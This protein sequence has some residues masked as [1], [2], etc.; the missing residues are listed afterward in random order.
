MQQSSAG[1]DTPVST[2]SSSIP[3]AMARGRPGPDYAQDPKARWLALIS[4]CLSLMVTSLTLSA[5]SIAIPAIADQLQASAVMVSWI[6]TALLWGSIVLMLPA[7]RVADIVGR[8]RVYLVGVTLFSI[9]SLLI[10][11]VG[12]IE[13]LLGLRVMQ[14]LSSSMVFGS[15]L[16]VVGSVFPPKARGQALGFAASSVYLGLTAGPLIGGWL[17]E[18]YGWRSVFWM[19]IPLTVLALL[20]VALFL[21]GEWKSET[22]ER[23]DWVGSLLFAA[24][25]SAAFLGISGLP[26]PESIALVGL[27]GALLWWF[28]RHQNRVEYPLI[29]LQVLRQN[30]LLRRSIKASLFMYG[31]NFP[32]VFLLS[33][34][35]QYIQSMSPSEAGQLIL[36]ETLVMMVLAPLA[37]RLSDRFEARIISTLGCLCFA[38]G[39][40]LLIWLQMDTSKLFIVIALAIL[41]LGFGLFSTPNNSAVMGA[42]PRSRMGIASA[43]LSLSRTLGNLVGTALVM[44]LISWSIGEVAIEPEQYPQL[45]WVVKTSLALSGLAALAA[46]Y[47]SFTRGSVHQPATPPQTSAPA[48]DTKGHSGGNS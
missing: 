35:L 48:A 42:V 10:F 12:S 46:C 41:G 27:G 38:F 26:E 33:L 5:A 24:W 4:V 39:F 44:M 23:L 3:P 28:I 21:K 11:T 32:I 17:T 31:A 40:G 6:P 7:G 36:I 15:G 16:A 9:S 8:K 25:V 47:Y 34:Y 30:R 2:P 29:R 22:P 13:A 18:L 14:G 20:L 45:L 19:P 37:G 1:A 43:M